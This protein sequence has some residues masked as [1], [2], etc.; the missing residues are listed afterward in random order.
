MSNNYVSDADTGEV[1]DDRTG[2]VV[3]IPTGPPDRS[4]KEEWKYNKD[5]SATFE[6]HMDDAIFSKK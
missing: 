2:R 6:P 4:N 5:G 3:L 1:K